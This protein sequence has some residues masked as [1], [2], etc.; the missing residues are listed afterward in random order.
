MGVTVISKLAAQEDIESGAVLYFP[1]SP[2]GSA[3]A[4][5]LNLVYNKNYHLSTSAERFVKVVKGM[6]C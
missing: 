5:D 3:S 4:R 6:Y 2:D 1:L